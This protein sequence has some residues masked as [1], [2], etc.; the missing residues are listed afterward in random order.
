VDQARATPADR[1][2]SLVIQTVCQNC[3]ATRVPTGRDP[4]TRPVPAAVA[5]VLLC[6]GLPT[7]AAAAD[8]YDDLLRVV[9]PGANALA[10]VNVK[11]A[12][13]SPLARAEKWAENHQ[14]KYWS[15]VGSVP[16]DAELVVVA[17]EVNLTA[18]ARQHQLGLVRLRNTISIPELVSREG[19]ARDDVAD[20]PV[21]L[22]PRNVYFAP[23]PRYLLA[24]VYPADRQA[25]AR[26]VRQTRAAG[27][28]GLAPYLQRAADQAGDA[29]VVVAIDLADALAP[30]VVR[31]GLSVS[32]VV[33]KR[34]VTNLDL[35]SRVVASVRGLTLT[36]VV[37]D[38]IVGTIRADFE[39]DPTLFRGTLRDLFVE[40]VEEQGVAITG[41]EN[42][43]V[44]FDDKSMTLSGP[45]TAADLRRVVSL[46]AFPGATGSEADA[47]GKDQVSVPAT[48]R[49]LAAVESI[50]EDIS[51][52]RTGTN[53]DKTATWHDRSAEQIEHLN[54]R[55]VDPLAVE[56]GLEAARRLR[57]IAGSLRGVPID[58]TALAAKQQYDLS[59]VILGGL[60]RG[61]FGGWG[62]SMS[63]NAPQIQDKMTR[64][65]ADDQR[66]RAEA[67]S[68]I[69]RLISEAKRQLGEKYKAAF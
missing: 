29:A 69:N 67:W 20:Q 66:Q 38:T 27:G 17:A 53:Y 48:Q 1:S 8:P 45:L 33:A 59:P 42:W 63:N 65:I 24:A 32:P 25:T 34:K 10:L 36:A 39:L 37:T 54:R 47:V 52:A 35:L 44:K 9:P 22:S 23:L 55:G 68:Q 62:L 56:A 50:L 6:W 11:A 21:V 26:W 31:Y 19:G 15:G 46:F 13:A 40:L 18:M 2:Y 14:K 43:D 61:V 30:A 12:H 64:V 57:A 3:A 28:P 51:R 49:Y 7:A 4:M 58:L 5:A 60:G 16:A 41:L